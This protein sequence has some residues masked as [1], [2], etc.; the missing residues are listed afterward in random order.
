MKI[1]SG[2]IGK[3]TLPVLAAAFLCTGT[4]AQII[5]GG[6]TCSA[7]FTRTN[8][9][10][11]DIALTNGTCTLPVERAQWFNLE[12]HPTFGNQYITIKCVD[13]SMW[14]TS[15]VAPQLISVRVFQDLTPSGSH[16]GC[17]SQV[18]GYDGANEPGP[19]LA[20]A[21]LLGEEETFIP[22]GVNP[23]V[24]PRL[25][26][27]FSVEFTGPQG[28]GILLSPDIAFFVVVAH[29][30]EA[31]TQFG[32]NASGEIGDNTPGA[33]GGI[34]GGPE[35]TWVRPFN[36]SVGGACSQTGDW[37]K[38]LLYYPGNTDT[39]MVIHL[40]IGDTRDPPQLA[41]DC[42]QDIAPFEVDDITGVV[43]IIGD[44]QVNVSDLL[45]LL[46]S[47]G[48]TA[49]PRPLGDMAPC[50]I[51]G[52]DCFGDNQVNVSD[53][54]TLL[55]AWGPC[56]NLVEDCTTATESGN[57]TAQISEGT[58]PWSIAVGLLEGAVDRPSTAFLSD[59]L[60]GGVG[61]CGWANYDFSDNLINGTGTAGGFT[62]GDTFGIFMGNFN[63]GG[64]TEDPVVIGG[65]V[66]FQYTADCNGRVF[67]SA[68][69]GGGTGEVVDTILEVYPG[70]ACPTDWTD[71]LLC[72]DN[73]SLDP[74]GNF[75]AVDLNVLQ[76]EKFLIR[77]AGWLGETGTGDLNISCVDNSFCPAALPILANAALV[78]GN[79]LNAGLSNPPNCPIN[80]DA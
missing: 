4:Q 74:L 25:D 45:V 76:G 34:T 73:S 23:A 50:P 13:F 28:G 7:S 65:D 3:G 79:T 6:Y 30:G 22:V 68:T 78:T 70:D 27:D 2:T 29:A 59:V 32:A 24:G 15:N 38:A 64:G 51:P 63:T 52:I 54:L 43:T 72:D 53:L 5:T 60:A 80:Q 47:W 37:V 58:F 11:L 40:D 61:I 33:P 62:W 18:G 1:R 12:G 57:L 55:G 77:I 21:L 42:R 19:D 44:K 35:Q 66:W 75:A 49:P 48:Q 31:I 56:P 39:V 69:S 67:I 41:F 26:G 14:G 20:S 46:G 9:I 71:V 10:S 8:N 17:D 36:C 16:N